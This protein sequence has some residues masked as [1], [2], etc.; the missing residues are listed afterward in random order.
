LH[1]IGTLHVINRKVS[2]TPCLL[3]CE[4]Q[5]IQNEA[6]IKEI[7]CIF[8]PLS[9]LKTVAFI[10]ANHITVGKKILNFPGGPQ[11]GWPPNHNHIADASVEWDVLELNGN[12]EFRAATPLGTKITWLMHQAGYVTTAPLANGKTVWTGKMSGCWIIK[13]T[14]A[15]NDYVAHVGT[16][17]GNHVLNDQAKNAWHNFLN[18]AN[19]PTNITGFNP[20]RD[21]PAGSA[22]A[23][24]GLYAIVNPNGDFF[25]LEIFFD[26]DDSINISGFHN[27][28]STLGAN[29]QIP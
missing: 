20:S 3:C 26:K 19:P 21:W 7:A 25:D 18:S 23:G 10:L 8:F 12:L 1:F 27:I 17:S 11:A 15:G 13:Y 16:E 5:S 14:H 9:F 6:D 28:G 29:G 4:I 22:R 24:D 2:D